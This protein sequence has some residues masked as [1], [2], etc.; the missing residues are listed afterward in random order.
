MQLP[1]FQ[2][3]AWRTGVL[4]LYRDILRTHKMVLPQALRVLGDKYVREEFKL[5]KSAQLG[6]SQQFMKQWTDYLVTLQKTA[7]IRELGRE[8]SSED[9]DAMDVEQ[10]AQIE[11]LRKETQRLG[12]D[13]SS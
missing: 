2:S 6:H 13:D 9:V 12:R 8:L 7:D 5:H 10:K 1:A 11:K 3:A 4:C